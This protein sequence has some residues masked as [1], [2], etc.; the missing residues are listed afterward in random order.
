MWHGYVLVKR[1]A[2]GPQFDRAARLAVRVTMAEL[3]LRYRRQ[4]AE[5]FQARESLNGDAAIYELTAAAAFLTP[6]RAIDAVAR[7]LNISAAALAAGIDY[8]VFAPD[9]TWDESAAA[10][11][12]YLAGHTAEWEPKDDDS[13]A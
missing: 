5:R 8:V 12:K 9:G 13:P 11:R 3:A 6:G 2:G 7:R 1:K 10:C 4:P